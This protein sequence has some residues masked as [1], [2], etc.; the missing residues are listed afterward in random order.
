MTKYTQYKIEVQEI[1]DYGHEIEVNDIMTIIKDSPEAAMDELFKTYVQP[2]PYDG[3]ES[4]YDAT[5]SIEWEAE[6]HT[7]DDGV[8]YTSTLSAYL[9]KETI[10]DMDITKHL[11]KG[12]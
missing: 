5:P 4:A 7:D 1:I 11:N 8:K 12:V 3:F 2:L 10:E 9:T 6:K